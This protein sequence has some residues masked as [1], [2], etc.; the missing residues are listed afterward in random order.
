[1]GIVLRNVEKSVGETATRIL[2]GISLSIPEEQLTAITGR[3]GS[4]KSS[5]LYVMSSLDRPSSGEIFIDGKNVYNLPD[6]E[7]DH[8]RNYTIGFI[9]Q[10]HF[11]L[12][13][14]S[15]LENVLLPSRAKGGLKSEFIDRSMGLIDYVGL[16]GKEHRLP[17]QLSGG[18][19]QRVAIARSIVMQPKYLF[20]DEPTGSLDSENGNKVMELLCRLTEEKKMTIVLVTHDQQF[21][22]LAKSRIRL[23]DGEVEDDSV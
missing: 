1:M 8:L 2:K 18:E 9:F 19:Q 11:L 23:K 14:L 7:L 4:G 17:R 3:S 13:E 6:S 20:A 10:F 16:S 15:V 12:P 22:N 21:A 5:L